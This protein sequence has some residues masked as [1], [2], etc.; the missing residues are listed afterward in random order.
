[1]IVIRK[2]N[3]FN[4]FEPVLVY[5]G[6]KEQLW[7]LPRLWESNVRLVG[8]TE[9]Q[10]AEFFPLP[11]FS[12]AEVD[13]D[14]FGDV[15]N[16]ED[17]VRNYP[18]GSESMPE[19]DTPEPLGNDDGEED[20]EGNEDPAEKAADAALGMVKGGDGTLTKEEYEAVD[21]ALR[22]AH[23][24][25][26]WFDGDDLSKAPP[27][28]DS[29]EDLPEYVV[30][31][32]REVIG[33][34]VLWDEFDDYSRQAARA[35]HNSLED[36]LTQP[37]GWSVSSIVDDLREMY[38]GMAEEK[39]L[40]IVQTELAAVFNSARERA[41]EK[42]PDSRDYVFY[43]GGPDDHRTTKICEEVK[44]EVED[45]GGAVPMAQLRSIL[46]EKA[47]KYQ[48]T[49]EGGT[50]ERVDSWVPHYRCRHSLIRDVKATL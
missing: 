18:P 47:R 27:A 6:E 3:D 43:W 45:R 17:F 37:Q 19:I 39:A 42:R 2:R 29:D 9:D 1:M 40:N 5:D 34:G 50:P 22:R 28:W 44:E 32:I 35:I 41:Y 49:R 38:S 30:E 11:N 46:R 21:D 10:F 48:N 8:L 33:E 31:A 20:E 13:S 24:R 15:P 26:A 16:A 14:P 4:D 12:V 23:E 25:V 7:G 36:N